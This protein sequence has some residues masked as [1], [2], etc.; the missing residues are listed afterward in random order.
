MSASERLQACWARDKSHDHMPYIALHYLPTSDFYIN[1]RIG[2]CQSQIVLVLL[3]CKAGLIKSKQ[4][5]SN[6]LIYLY[7]YSPIRCLFNCPFAHVFLHFCLCLTLC[8][9]T[10]SPSSARATVRPLRARVWCHPTPPSL[11][12]SPRARV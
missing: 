3:G 4:N 1:T 7:T 12:H 11:T 9:W 8:D 2:R 10:L 5:S 6:L